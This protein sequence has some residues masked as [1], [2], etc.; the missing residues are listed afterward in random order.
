VD[1]TGAVPPVVYPDTIDDCPAKE[2]LPCVKLPTSVAFTSTENGNLSTVSTTPGV[3]GGVL[4]PPELYPN[5]DD[6]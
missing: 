5:V 2:Y 6:D 1:G 3:G 4:Y